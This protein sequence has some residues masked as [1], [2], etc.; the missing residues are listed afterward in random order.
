MITYGY[1]QKDRENLIDD[2]VLPL[3]AEHNWNSSL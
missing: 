1:K 2:M 3:C